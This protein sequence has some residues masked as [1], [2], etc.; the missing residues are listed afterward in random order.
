MTYLMCDLEL[1]SR[2]VRP[3]QIEGELMDDGLL[4]GYLAGALDDDGV[5]AVEAALVESG[6]ARA[7]LRALAA[8][9][10]ALGPAEF[11][12][13][14]SAFPKGT[15]ARW[16]RWAA[17]GGALA[18][19]ALVFFFVR[20]ADPG[21]SWRMD[22]PRGGVQ[23]KRAEK[24]ESTVFLPHSKFSVDLVPSGEADQLPVR[25]YVVA[26]DQLQQRTTTV[27]RSAQ[28][29]IQVVATGQTLFGDQ[30]G[31]RRVW[32]VLGDPALDKRPTS[33]IDALDMPAFK[34]DIDYRLEP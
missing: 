17:I 4:L 29:A 2:L 12:A 6:P 23:L 20:P 15:S 11:A 33:A 18:A 30:P 21:V 34:V 24:V 13:A 22:G 9:Q 27:T 7:Q 19:A 31:Q 16:T 32:I 28:G 25:V 10:T 26:Q 14:E 3:P 8:A 5:E 1:D